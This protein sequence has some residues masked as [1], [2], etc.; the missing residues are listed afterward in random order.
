MPEVPLCVNFIKKRGCERS[1]V[2][3]TKETPEAWCFTCATCELLQVVSKDSI[4]DKSKFELA[5][6]RKQEHEQ[7]MRLR[8]K[9]VKIFT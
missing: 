5:A 3:L 7:M 4:K 6:R 8:D 9:K 1:D 2:K